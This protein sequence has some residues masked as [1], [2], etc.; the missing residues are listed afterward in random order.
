MFLPPGQRIMDIYNYTSFPG[1]A[2]PQFSKGE[3]KDSRPCISGR[4][5]VN[6]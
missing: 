6:Y 1:K 3:K 4:T 2:K 5:T